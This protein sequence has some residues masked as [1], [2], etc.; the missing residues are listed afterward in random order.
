MGAGCVLGGG[1]QGASWEV[2]EE[3]EAL[4]YYPRRASSKFC[5]EN[6]YAS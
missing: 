2:E 1:D 3:T 4:L 5:M 6:H